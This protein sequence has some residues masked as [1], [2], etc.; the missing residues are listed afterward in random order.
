[1]DSCA[2]QRASSTDGTSAICWL[3]RFL[4]LSHSWPIRRRR[5]PKLTDSLM[6]SGNSSER[7]VRVF[8]PSG[9][10]HAKRVREAHPCE[11]AET[12]ADPTTEF[13]RHGNNEFSYIPI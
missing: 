6:R 9:P 13:K 3:A 7:A 5:T 10:C 8:T 12:V 11:C 1:M 2:L 4:T